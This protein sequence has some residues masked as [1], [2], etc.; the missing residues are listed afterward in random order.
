MVEGGCREGE[1][2]KI[3]YS[4]GFLFAPYIYIYTDMFFFWGECTHAYRED[5]DMVI[6]TDTDSFLFNMF[7]IPL[8][9]QMRDIYIY[10]TYMHAEQDARCVIYIHL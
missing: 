10:T 6:G 1:R 5:V 7:H 4:Y 9:R 3:E 2:E 8:S